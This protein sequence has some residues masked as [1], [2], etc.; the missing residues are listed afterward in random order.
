MKVVKL[1]PYLRFKTQIVKLTRPH[2]TILHKILFLFSPTKVVCSENVPAHAQQN[3]AEK[4]MKTVREIFSRKE[5][6]EENS[7]NFTQKTETTV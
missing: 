6:F 1:P 7:Y 4:L 5:N 2:S 3:I